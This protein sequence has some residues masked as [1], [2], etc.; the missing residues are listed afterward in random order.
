[1]QPLS[2]SQRI[3]GVVERSLHDTR[4]TTSRGSYH[5]NPV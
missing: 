1:M 5:F 3:I 4:K 2:T